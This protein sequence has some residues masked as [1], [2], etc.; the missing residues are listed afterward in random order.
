VSPNLQN[1]GKNVQKLLKMI[2]RPT[3]HDINPFSPNI[4]PSIPHKPLKTTNIKCIQFDIIQT[5]SSA[6]EYSVFYVN[7]LP[8][9][10]ANM[11][12]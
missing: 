2:I 12:D 7:S 3:S 8:C 5:N 6:Y 10:H 1:A 4:K 11:K 9:L